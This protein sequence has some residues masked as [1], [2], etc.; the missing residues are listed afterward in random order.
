ML[1]TFIIRRMVLT[2]M[3]VMMKYSKGDDTTTL[4]SLYLKLSLFLGMYLS[5]GSACTVTS[6]L[7][8]DSR[9]G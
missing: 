1:D 4:Q 7:G 9:A 6:S 5:R 2:T 8:W 3:R